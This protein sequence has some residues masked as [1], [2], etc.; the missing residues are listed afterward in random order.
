MR[1]VAEGYVP[2]P[3]GAVLTSGKQLAQLTYLCVGA[4]MMEADDE[5]N[6]CLTAGELQ[7][8]VSSCPNLA[9]LD[10]CHA[11]Q[12]GA[13]APL[14]ALTTQCTNLIVGGTAVDDDAASSVLC[15]LTHLESLSLCDAPRLTDSGLEQFT[16]LTAL[17]SLNVFDCLGCSP[18]VV[19]RD[20]E[21]D[22]N[23]LDLR[24]A[25][26]HEVCP[27]VEAIQLLDVSVRSKPW[28]T[29]LPKPIA[30]TTLFPVCL[31]SA[32]LRVQNPTPVWRQL[33]EACDRSPLIAP[34]RLQL[35]NEK[36]ERLQ[37]EVAELQQR[38]VQ[39]EEQLAHRS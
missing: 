1:V 5:E 30:T 8:L 31:P 15:R 6:P 13:V 2:L 21:C 32:L 16:A 3:R 14:L 24:T 11:L 26:S 27:C 12:P 20:H 22:G 7:R 38:V 9:S 4:R 18:E 33:R 10:L 34:R 19:P 37:R 35:Q 23:E 28:C 29:A 36:V 17:P 39:L 25:G